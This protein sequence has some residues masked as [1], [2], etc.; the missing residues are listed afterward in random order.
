MNVYITSTP[1]I[2]TNR[3]NQVVGIL[4]KVKGPLSFHVIEKLTSD[5]FLPNINLEDEFTHIS[6]NELNKIA[7]REREYFNFS[8][9]DFYVILTSHKLDNAFIPGKNWFSYFNKK[10]I[11]VRTYG[12]EDY[13]NRRPQ[14]AIAHQII[15][16]IFQS[17]SGYKYENYDYYHN[18]A[19]GCINDFCHNEYEIEFKL[20][21]GH[22][23]KDCLDIAVENG[24]TIE[25]V[26][27]IRRY[28]DL[29]R[30]ELLDIQS[31]INEMNVPKVRITDK[32]EIMVGERLI[33]IKHINRALYIFAVLNRGEVLSLQFLRSRYN[34][35]KNIYFAIKKTGNDKAVKTFMGVDFNKNGERVVVRELS[36]MNKYVKFQL[37]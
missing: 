33:D 35:F 24:I 21:T 27:Q 22:I 18:R 37:H 8:S 16:N 5:S 11:F 3:I 12:W 32:G 25:I 20:R 9:E 31:T 15:E 2:S 10:N 17:I 23:C 34:E 7:N 19:K 28:L 1:E 6:F 26:G 13:T 14:I 29:F 4:N 30:Q 36:K